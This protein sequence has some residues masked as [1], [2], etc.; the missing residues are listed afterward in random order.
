MDKKATYVNLD[1]KAMYING[2][3]IQLEEQIKIHNPATQEIFATVPKGGVTEAKQAVDAAHEA[4]KSWSKLTAAERAEKLRKWFTLID[5]NKEEIAAIMTREQ[6]KPFLEALGEVNYANSFV[7][8]YAEEGKRVYGEM[9]PAS[10]PNKRIL[11]TKQPVGVIAAITPWNFPAA[12]ITRKV[13]PALAA[14]CTAVVK[15]ASQTPLTALKLAELAHEANIPKGVLNIV[16]GSAK[17]IADAWMEDGRVRKVSFTGSTEIGKELMSSAAKTMKKVSLELGGH[18]PFIVMNDADLDKA[19]EAVIGSKFRN[20]GQTCICTNRVFVQE[21]VYEEFVAKFKKAVAQLKV[22]DGFG[23]GTTVGPLID[24]NAVEKV[25]EHI[26]DAVKKGGE[27]L[28]GG[29]TV[30]E[31]NGHFIEPTV[32]GGANDTMLCMTEE[33]FGPVAP[34]A[35]FKTVEEVIERANNTPYGLAAYIFTKDM[36]QA[37]QISEALE[38]GII[39]LND[40]LPSVAQAPFGG[41]KESGI[42]REGG[43]FGIEEY[44]EI[45]YI[46]LGL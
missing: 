21:A 11:V 19:V 44:L 26:E 38:Y 29:Q 8:W 33:T 42:G 16:T 20:A 13:A 22:G 12:M 24:A 7:E 18:A 45:K 43:H 10:H 32:I 35:K 17:A 41:F 36:S 15:P 27:I 46:S 4:F 2:E 3:W 1:Q 28:Y 6:G 9:I 39:G 34:V 31:L 40:G 30:T 5:E 25:Q 23:E 37:F 14:G